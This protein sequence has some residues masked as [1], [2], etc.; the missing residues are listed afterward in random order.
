MANNNCEINWAKSKKSHWRLFYC[1]IFF[2]LFMLAIYFEF[3]LR[4]FRADWF[5]TRSQ[6]VPELMGLSLHTYQIFYLYY[7]N[8]RLPLV[9]VVSLSSSEI[10]PLYTIFL[11]FLLEWFRTPALRLT[12]R[13]LDL[14]R[15]NLPSFLSFERYTKSWIRIFKP[16]GHDYVTVWAEFLRF[17]S[18]IT[19]VDLVEEF[20]ALQLV[21]HLMWICSSVCHD[22]H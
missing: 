11:L 7:R 4:C 1:E 3:R 17:Q 19:F 5:S 10:Q 22:E 21:D 18:V 15:S 20:L 8:A 14:G 12:L 9:S 6:R 16:C 13:A 2:E